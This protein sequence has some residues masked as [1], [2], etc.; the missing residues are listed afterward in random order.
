M[1]VVIVAGGK[2]T[3]LRERLGGLPKPMVSI[4]G[5]PLLEHQVLLACHHGFSDVILLLGHG[6]DSITEYFGDGS[7][8][9]VHIRAITES[10]PLG[11]AGA[12]LAALPELQDRFLVMYGDTM[13]NID[14][15]RFWRAH[16]KS[17]ADASLL[18]HPNDHPH[19]SDLVEIEDCGRITAFHPYP[20]DPDRFY[21]N[22][23][24]A[25]L[26]IVERRALVRWLDSG[27]PLDFAKDL[28]PSMLAQ[29]C[30]LQGYRSPEYIKDAGTPERLDA[31]ATDYESGRIA[32]G[33]L[34]TPTPAIFLDRDG[35]LNEEVDRVSHLDDFSLMEGVG[36]AIRRINRAGYRAVVITNQPVIARGDCTENDLT[37]I[38]NKLETL[39]GRDGAYVDAILHC[40]HHPDKGFPGER[41]DLKIACSCR[42]P[43]IGLIERA[44]IA[45]NIDMKRS[46]FIGDSTVDI[47]TAQNAGLRSILLQTGYGGR[48][49]RY[50]DRPDYIAPSL[51]TAV[52]LALSAPGA[53][54]EQL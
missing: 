51:S 31:V 53:R 22:L 32:R 27:G 2:G 38:H 47:R 13:L 43:A 6:A 35:T 3:R 40:P 16:E 20:H 36:G 14:L 8:L 54:E 12:V 42:K 24:N 33:S 1:Q 28:F 45:F 17:G 44:R 34:E 11:S 15:T 7:R 4:A 5:K 10:V 52:D 25:A 41:T 46:W 18:L 37:E 49:G 29:G 30:F 26:Y 21:A 9:G 23:V 48:D 19:D 39:L 50:P